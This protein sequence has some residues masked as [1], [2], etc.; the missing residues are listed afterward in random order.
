MS[1]DRIFPGQ[2]VVWQHRH[3]EVVRVTEYG[4]VII[5]GDGLRVPVNTRAVFLTPDEQ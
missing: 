1:I 4:D 5:K 3:V 2:H